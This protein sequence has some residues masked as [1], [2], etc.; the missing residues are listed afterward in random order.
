MDIALPT[1]Y[2]KFQQEVREFVSERWTARAGD[3]DDK[4]SRVWAFREDAIAAGYLLRHIPKRYG[5][6]EQPYDPILLMLIDQ[7]FRSA[8]VVSVLHD[9]YVGENLL[10]PTILAMGSE[11]QKEKFVIPTLRG[12]IVWSQGYSEPNTGSDLLSL[13]TRA[14][15]VDD[16][17][18]VNGQK[19]WTTNAGRSDYMFALVRTEKDKRPSQSLSYLVIDMKSEGVDARPFEVMTG[20]QH[21]GE[22]F[23]ENVKVPADNLVGNR[24]EGW[25]VGNFTLS[26]ERNVVGS[27][28]E[29]LDSYQLLVELA[30]TTKGFDGAPVIDDP[31]IQDRLLI[32]EGYVRGHHLSG[33]R[34]LS[35][36]A[37]NRNPYPLPM[38]NKLSSTNV[39]EM[40]AR[41]SSD[42]MALDILRQ[43]PLNE[44]PGNNTPAFWR[45][46]Y[47]WAL[48]F[49]IAGGTSN[50][51][52][53]IIAEKVLNLPRDYRG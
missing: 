46:H 49:A 50:I 48:G 26:T 13:K 30:K 10:V 19:I 9:H 40:M 25:K 12:D 3:F 4:E 17:W 24:G 20:A 42:I 31:V 41:L 23:L 15:F 14:E 22:V 33:Y 44:D 36:V 51:Q 34:Q 28:E 16:H 5:G 43:P 32:I 21:F 8:D 1:K 47:Y 38:F 53:N 18:L 37:N 35:C 2:K 27:A 29:L 52:R 45:H 6:S 7:A 11:E 39:G